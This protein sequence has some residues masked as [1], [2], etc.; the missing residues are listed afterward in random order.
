MGSN[1]PTFSEEEL[2]ELD[3]EGERIAGIVG[4]LQLLLGD[5]DGEE[6]AALLHGAFP[7]LIVGADADPLRERFGAL[8]NDIRNAMDTCDG[9]SGLGAIAAGSLNGELRKMEADI[10]HLADYFEIKLP[11]PRAKAKG[12]P[13]HKGWIV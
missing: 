13:K 8:L 1:S 10:N 6:K 3:E 11:A 5:L 4:A 9:S 2:R 7:G 12:K